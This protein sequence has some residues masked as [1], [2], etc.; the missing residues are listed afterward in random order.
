[1]TLAPAAELFAR[2]LRGRP[3][4]VQGPP[5]TTPT[6]LD[7]DTWVRNAD[8]GDLSLLDRCPGPVLDVGCGPGRMASALHRRGVA[9]LGIDVVPE[10]VTQTRRRGGVGLQRDVFDAVPAEGSWRTVLLAD[11]N[12][13]IGGDPG[14]LLR[15]VAQLLAPGGRVVVEVAAPGVAQSAFRTTLRC[16]GLTSPSFPWAVLGVDDVAAAAAS[17]GLRV[18]T[19][20]ELHGRWCAV[21]ERDDPSATDPGDRD[22]RVG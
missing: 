19:V 6:D 21:L 3:C 14:A 8:A 13:G 2:A 10:A 9:A 20:E 4:T 18:R 22:D 15:R 11:G 1:M 7:V 16:D 17:A 5:H 12:I